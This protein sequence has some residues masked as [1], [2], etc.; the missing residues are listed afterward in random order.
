LLLL[1]SLSL[2][3]TSSLRPLVWPSFCLDWPAP[4]LQPTFSRTTYS[5]SR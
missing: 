1:I 5:S 2:L 4:V 3:Q